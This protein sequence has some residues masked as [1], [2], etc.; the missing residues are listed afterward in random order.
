MT[1]LFPMSDLAADDLLLDRLGGRGEPG[2]E[3]VA[4]LLGA[5]AAHADTPLP[6]RTRRRRTARSHRYVG[7]FAALA[8]AASG[9]GVA[10]AVTIP[11]R[12][13][14]LADRARIEQKM[15]ESAR[16]D[17]PSA[18]LTRLGLPQVS[19]VT[20]ASGLVLYR[21]PDGAIVLLPASVVAA[22]NAAGGFALAVGSDS[23]VPGEAQ[24]GSTAPNG[25]AFGAGQAGSASAGS[26]GGDTQ[27][28]GSTDPGNDHGD[29]NGD[30]NGDQQEP[31]AT[32]TP[33]PTGGDQNGNAKVGKGKNVVPPTPK[34][35]PTGTPQPTPTGTPT[36]D[37]LVFSPTPPTGRASGSYNLRSTI[38]SPHPTPTGSGD[39]DA[40]LP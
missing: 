3:T 8:V 34:P 15:R 26:H 32:P 23:I 16:S 40:G 14:S 37:S 4:V 20:E 35:V 2:G 39:Q 33:P 6:A 17:A 31:Q 25:N 36:A 18:L 29:D 21:R 22:A 30:D 24:P 9:V 5:L 7:A 11:D 19:G 10:A 27:T 1:D 38:P 13:L 28:G 12:G